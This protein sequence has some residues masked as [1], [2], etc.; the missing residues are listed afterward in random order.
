MVPLPESESEWVSIIKGVAGS[1]AE[2]QQWP[3]NSAKVLFQ[4]FPPPEREC[5]IHCECSLIEYIET[6][7]GTSWENVPP[8]NYIGV[9]KLS[10]CACSLWIESFNELGGRAFFTKGSHGKWCWPWGMPEVEERVGKFMLRKLTSEY[11]YL[12]S[13]GLIRTS[14][15]STG[16]DSEGEQP[17]TNDAQE[18]TVASWIAARV[19]E[20]GGTRVGFAQTLASKYTKK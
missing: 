8:F 6:K 20:A 13:R 15:D 4:K 9:S 5:V 17:Q 14:S 3:D 19:Q 12:Q 16:A 18:K 2:K 11:L 1:G 10:C 7:D